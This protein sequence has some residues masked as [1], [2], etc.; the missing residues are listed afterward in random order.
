VTTCRVGPDPDDFADLVPDADHQRGASPAGERADA[1]D[2][3]PAA[4]GEARPG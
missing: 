3:G 4:G 1:G 2:A